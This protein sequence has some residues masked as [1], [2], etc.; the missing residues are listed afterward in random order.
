VIN[1][2]VYK[3]PSLAFCNSSL[4][5]LKHWTWLSREKK[6]CQSCFPFLGQHGWVSEVLFLD[7]SLNRS[8]EQ[9][10]QDSFTRALIP[11]MWALPTCG[12]WTHDLII[13]KWSHNLKLLLWGLGFQHK[14]FG[15]TQVLD[16]GTQRGDWLV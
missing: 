1:N 13:F 7:I 15:R 4:H 2:V 11:F 6:N 12:F 14:N 9:V 5:A 8:D 10:F 3:R 16:H